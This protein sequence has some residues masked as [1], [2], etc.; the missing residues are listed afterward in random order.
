MKKNVTISFIAGLVISGAA[1][2][3]A[4]KNI[5]LRELGRYLGS[6]NYFWMVPA[7]AI[8]LFSFYLRAVRWRLILESVR[9]I[10]VW[11]AYH[12][13]IIGFMINCVLPGRLGEVARPAILQKEEKIAFTTGLATVAAERA[14]DIFFLVALFLVTAGMVKIDP[15]LNMAFGSHQL[16]RET[17]VLVFNTLVKLGVVLIAGIVLF[18]I[19]NVRGILY[20]A[21]RFMP[22]L[23]FFAG[24]GF[25][26]AFGRRVCEPV[27]GILENIARGFSLVRYPRRIFYCATLSAIIWALQA[28]SYYLVS[29]GCPGINLGF[30]EIAAAMVIICFFISLPSVPG[31]WGLWEAAGVFA[32]SLFGVA[33]KQAAGYTLVNH[34][35]QVLP[36]IIAG[37]GSALFLSVNIGKIAYQPDI[38]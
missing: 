12:P 28:L 34:A 4:F 2:Y 8:S 17:L 29:L 11:R 7:V 38:T 3:F 6:I 22:R 9:K 24:Q 27:I 16:N 23:F 1:L 36:V 14:F 20:R 10:G 21:I 31:W 15:D 37:L 32:L 19:G 5:P 26:A 30:F 13:M 33:S 25:Q 35:L 18:S